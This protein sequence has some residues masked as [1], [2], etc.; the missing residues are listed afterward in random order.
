MNVFSNRQACSRDI[1]KKFVQHQVLKFV[2]NGGCWGVG[3]RKCASQQLQYFAKNPKLMKFN[4]YHNDP[5]TNSEKEIYKPGSLRLGLYANGRLHKVDIYDVFSAPAIKEHLKN[6][7]EVF[8]TGKSCH[9]FKGCISNEKDLVRMGQAIAYKDK[10]GQNCFGEFDGAIALLEF[11]ASNR[12]WVQIIS[13]RVQR[14]ENEQV[15]L[16]KFNCPVLEKTNRK[17]IIPSTSVEQRVNVVH[18]CSSGCK[19]TVSGKAVVEEREVVSHEGTTFQHDF[20]N[21]RY[22]LNRFFL[23]GNI[24]RFL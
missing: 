22:L 15:Q 1:G 24:I 21:G 2:L 8:C 12:N 9:Y 6:H 13:Y 10:N 4:M 3:Y 16:G 20:A 5:K 18:D 14:D 11:G 23:G 19:F 7:P 17:V